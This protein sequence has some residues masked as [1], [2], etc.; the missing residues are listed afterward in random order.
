MPAGVSG[1]GRVAAVLREQ[2][3]EVEGER[4]DLRG[5]GVVVGDGGL[6]SARHPV[7]DRDRLLQRLQT[8]KPFGPSKK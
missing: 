6:V 7:G 8:S 5:I 1:A 2:P 4:V 3:E